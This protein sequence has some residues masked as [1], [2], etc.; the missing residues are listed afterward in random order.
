MNH[1]LKCVLFSV[2]VV[3]MSAACTPV[4][5]TDS[6]ED[7]AVSTAS[8]TGAVTSNEPNV[9]TEPPVI[10]LADNLDE[11]DNL[12]WCIDT[13]GRGQ[14][15]RLHAHS[16]KPTG[17]SPQSSDV[18]FSYDAPSG[19]IKSV[20][21]DNQ[22]MIIADATNVEIQF[23]LTD[24]DEAN[25]AQQFTYDDSSSEIRPRDDA[26]LCLTVAR[27]SRTAGPFMS[28]DLKLETCGEVP[29]EYKRWIILDAS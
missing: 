7:S 1:V 23:G 29:E 6:A 21:F 16:C 10:Y 11:K 20:A 12:G 27:E 18:R 4:N 22:C 17:N 25:V 13:V 5:P 3:A 24:C 19:Q 28:R 9:Q 26:T 2:I 8:S 15:D 14:S